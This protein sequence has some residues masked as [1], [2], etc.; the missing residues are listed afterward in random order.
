M[1]NMFIGGKI[2][3]HAV[4]FEDPSVLRI[5]MAMDERRL[6]AICEKVPRGQSN[7]R[8]DRIHKFSTNKAMEGGHAND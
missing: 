1:V 2:C 6:R 5:I 3:S 7:A 4:G 8:R